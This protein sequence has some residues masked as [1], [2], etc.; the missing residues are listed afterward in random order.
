MRVVLDTNVLLSLYVFSDSCFAP[1]RSCIEAGSWLALTNA[2]CLDEFRRVLAYP[3]FAL[4]AAAQ[5]AALD[6]YC[7]CAVAVPGTT[8]ERFSLPRCSDNDDQKF[9]ELAR[10]GH[11]HSLIT[12]D[13]ALLVL[14]RRRKMAGRFRIIGPEVAL[15]ELA[16]VAKGIPAP[17]R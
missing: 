5:Q 17:M 16:P 1:L 6:S 4:E 2:V 13:K 11:A 10:D 8:Q 3:E 14:A 15:S 7:A 9:L 12:S